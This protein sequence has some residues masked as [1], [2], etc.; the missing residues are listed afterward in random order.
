MNLNFVAFEEFDDF[1]PSG[2]YNLQLNPEEL[3]I[4]FTDK[5]NQA[6]NTFIDVMFEEIRNRVVDL[7]GSC[8][9]KVLIWC[10]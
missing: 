7:A 9:R 10:L 6:R 1:Y 2:I 5:K 3:K 8:G 4:G